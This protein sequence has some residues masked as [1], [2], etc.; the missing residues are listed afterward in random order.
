MLFAGMVIPQLNTYHRERPPPA[1]E[2]PMQMSEFSFSP[3]FSKII[4]RVSTDA[5]YILY[6]IPYFSD[7]KILCFRV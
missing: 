3:T 6:F 1:T 2:A 7:I 4:G 5:L